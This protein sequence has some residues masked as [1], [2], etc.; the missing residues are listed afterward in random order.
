[1]DEKT[2]EF[3]DGRAVDCVVEIGAPRTIANL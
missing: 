2:R 3:T 1:L